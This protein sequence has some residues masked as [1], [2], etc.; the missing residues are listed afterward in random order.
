VS[1][2]IA[3]LG[4]MPEQPNGRDISRETAQPPVDESDLVARNEPPEPQEPDSTDHDQDKI[5]F[6][7]D[8]APGSMKP[9]PIDILSPEVIESLRSGGQ[10]SADD[11][12]KLRSATW[13][14]SR[15][16]GAL[17]DEIVGLAKRQDPDGTDST[18]PVDLVGNPNVVVVPGGVQ[19]FEWTW[20]GTDPARDTAS[21]PETYYEALTGQPD[22]LRGFFV[23]SRRVLNAVTWLI[24]LGVPLGLV[25]VGV[26]AGA[27]PDTIFFMG[28]AGLIVGMMFKSSFPKTPFG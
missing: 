16:V 26:V 3:E 2:E 1:W 9:L 7:V 27:S 22:P 19:K 13:A 12:E 11:L 4:N 24:A 25:T 20:K 10:L 21:E 23:A 8:F 28:L 18:L 5:V 17:I 14:D 15:V 6:S